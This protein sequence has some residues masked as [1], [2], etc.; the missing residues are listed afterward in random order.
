MTT[1][2]IDPTMGKIRE[3]WAAR[4]R[5][6]WSLQRLGLAMGYPANQAKQAASQFLR[7]S[8]PRLSSVRRFAVAVGVSP[9]TLMRG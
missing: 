3:I 1:A 6:G 8:D 7:G 4:Q 5:A 2:T 9:A